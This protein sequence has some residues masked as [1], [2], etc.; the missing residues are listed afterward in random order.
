MRTI[1]FLCFALLLSCSGLKKYTVEE[2]VPFNEEAVQVIFDDEISKYGLQNGEKILDLGSFTGKFS[3][4]IFRNYPQT[5]FTLVDVYNY[6]KLLFNYSFERNDSTYNFRK[7]RR[8]VKSRLTK[9][10]LKS[11]TFDKILCRRTYHEFRPFNK[12][13]MLAEMKRLL[14]EDGELIIVDV[15][16]NYLGHTDAGCKS[17]YLEANTIMH[18]VKRQGFTFVKE[19]STTYKRTDSTDYNLSILKFKKQ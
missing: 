7:N 14:K 17:L 13:L 5:K 10:P 11:N 2:N 16:P 4:I 18:E 3:A 19:D 12:A 15:I 9:I 8:F 6:K 1:L